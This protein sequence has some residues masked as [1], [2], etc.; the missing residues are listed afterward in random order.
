M[1]NIAKLWV[2]EMIA[3]NIQFSNYDEDLEM[4]KRIEI[5][6]CNRVGKF[7]HNFLRPISVTFAKR[8]DKEEFL[9]NKRQLPSGIFANE[10]YL[11]HIKRNPDHL[12]PILWLTKTLAQYR[13]KSKL[14]QDCLV[15]NGTSYKVDDIPNLPADLAAFKAAEKSNDTHTAFAGD[16]SP[17]SN[18][19]VSPFIING[20]KF[21]GSEQWI[22]YQKALTFGDS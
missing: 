19:H 8:D 21:H 20:Q 14:V 6:S 2:H 10:E 9:P 12:R 4:A 11:L 16:L 3:T 15:I 1:N 17:Y 13:E 22:Q 5:T 18:L 7:R